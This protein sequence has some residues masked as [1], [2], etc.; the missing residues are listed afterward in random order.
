M[1]QIAFLN[2]SIEGVRLTKSPQVHSKKRLATNHQV[3]FLGNSL[4]PAATKYL[5]TLNRMG[6][7]QEVVR[8]TAVS[9]SLGV[10]LPSAL[11]MLRTLAVQ[12]YLDY[13][14]RVGAKL[15]AAG[16]LLTRRV[17]RRHALIEVF[18]QRMER[19]AWW[20][21]HTEAERLQYAVSQVV[22]ERIAVELGKVATG[23]YGHP[24]PD[25][26]LNV[27]SPRLQPLD[28]IDLGQRWVVR[29]VDDDDQERLRQWHTH[30]L[31]PGATLELVRRRTG[32]GAFRVKIDDTAVWLEPTRLHGLWGE[33]IRHLNNS[34]E[35]GMEM[36]PAAANDSG[37]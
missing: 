23:P 24:I 33:H 8:L 16:V 25:Q 7:A 30:G 34:I 1:S 32:D 11:V 22:E 3:A 21:L 17:F 6:G 10:S 4:T 28:R 18:L 35:G 13:E 15:T 37:R 14:R 36:G 27:P 19:L 5:M 12:G 9:H 2:R 26:L 29:Q 20:E 31:V